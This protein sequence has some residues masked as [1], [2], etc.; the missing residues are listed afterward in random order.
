MALERMGDAQLG[1][2]VAF[3]VS[4]GIV[5]EIIAKAC[6]SPQTTEL[7]AATRAATL[8]KWVHIGQAEA[9]AL[10]FIAAWIDKKHRTAILSGGILAMVITEAEYLHA[11]S[12][13]LSKPGAATEQHAASGQD[14]LRWNNPG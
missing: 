3:L 1:N 11:K 12:A 4:A 2:G 10:L 6:S 7:N 14:M 5:Y 13:G 8:M 9:A